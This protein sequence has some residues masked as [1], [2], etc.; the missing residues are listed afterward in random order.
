MNIKEELIDAPNKISLHKPVMIYKKVPVKDS[1]PASV[2]RV[3]ITTKKRAERMEQFLKMKVTDL[4][5]PKKKEYA[6]EKALK[7]PKD[8]LRCSACNVLY[9]RINHQQHKKD[10]NRKTGYKY[11]C[12]MC[13]FTHSDI[14]ELQRHIITCRKEK[15]QKL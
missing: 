11:G 14:Q 6:C 5:K 12:V 1:G 4:P 10:C 3:I 13:N 9:E 15:N 8:T 7:T 2:N